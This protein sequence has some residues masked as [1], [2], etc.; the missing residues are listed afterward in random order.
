MSPIFYPYPIWGWY[1]NYKTP[2]AEVSLTEKLDDPEAFVYEM[3]INN[4]DP[5]ILEL[6]NNGKATYA[7][8]ATCSS[9]FYNKFVTSPTPHI[10]IKISRED[11]FGDVEIKFLIVATCDIPN[12]KNSNLNDFY[13][14]EAFLPKGAAI[15]ILKHGQ[16]EATPT[17]GKRL[18]D[19]IKVVENTVDENIE[20]EFDNPCIRIALPKDMFTIFNDYASDYKGVLHSTI[21]YNALLEAV[22]N[23]P[24][25]ESSEYDWVKYVKKEIENMDDILPLDELIA[26]KGD[27]A[28]YSIAEA[29]KICDHILKNPFFRAF[30]DLEP[31]EP[32]E[33]TES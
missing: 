22:S 10:S 1:E 19:V 27:D 4:N 2:K 31:A 29:M 13:E 6:I 12:Y 7:C 32:S 21:V 15:A 25:Y 9:T 17:S 30:K 33:Q 5:A 18:G 14:N 28:T 16:F 20:Y 23:L 8:I 11:V 3:D 26:E 24:Q